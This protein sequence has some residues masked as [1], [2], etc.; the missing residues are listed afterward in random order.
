MSS[1]H[2][3]SR[4]AFEVGGIELV[5]R[6]DVLIF[7]EFVATVGFDLMGL[8]VFEEILDFGMTLGFEF[9]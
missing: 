5:E 4:L 9:S 1:Q 7:D 2:S 8:D 3:T 6:F